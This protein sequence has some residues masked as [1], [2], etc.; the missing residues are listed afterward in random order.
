MKREYYIATSDVWRQD[1]WD[2]GWRVGILC[3]VDDATILIWE[4][5]L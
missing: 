3:Q 5:P 2:S 1:L 4:S